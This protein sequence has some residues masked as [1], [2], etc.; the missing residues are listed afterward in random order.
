MDTIKKKQRHSTFDCAPGCSVEAAISVIDGKW[1]GVILFHLLSEPQRFNALRRSLPNIS[2]RML[3]IQ[4]R[5]LEADGL[6]ERHVFAEVPARVEYSLS[7]LGQSLT[8]ILK[9]LKSWGD[10]NLHLFAGAKD[11]P[12]DSKAA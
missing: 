11:K 4:L 6:I 5:E 10:D 2:Q 1:K 3:A 9:A 7:V 8:P 12:E